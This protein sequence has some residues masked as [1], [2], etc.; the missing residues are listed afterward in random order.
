M[1]KM[2]DILQEVSLN[3]HPI[4]QQENVSVES[5]KKEESQAIDHASAD[6]KVFLTFS[7]KI[8]PKQTFPMSEK[9]RLERNNSLPDVHKY[10]N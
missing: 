5:P 9:L 6:A 2:S 3:P 8:R 10:R 4:S 7:E 1:E